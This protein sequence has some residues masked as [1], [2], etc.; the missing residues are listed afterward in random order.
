M[1]CF[2][3]EVDKLEMDRNEMKTKLED[4]N[5]QLNELLG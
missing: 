1:Y 5:Q 3:D 4:Q 2:L